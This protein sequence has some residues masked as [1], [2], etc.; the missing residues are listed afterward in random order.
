MK[1]LAVLISLCITHLCLASSA[2]AQTP[3][4]ILTGQ[5]EKQVRDYFSSLKDFFRSNKYV[6]IEQKTSDDGDLILQFGTPTLQEEIT[7]S[8]SIITRFIMLNDG[9]EVCTQQS[10]L[11]TEKSAY[12]NLSNIKKH[13]ARDPEKEA[14]WVREYNEH[15]IEVAEF[16]KQDNFYEIKISMVSKK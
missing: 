3:V 10:I 7:S 15:F 6:E 16:H 5:T 4:K 12:K 8:L 13:F 1:K 9:T 11:G 2:L 14:V